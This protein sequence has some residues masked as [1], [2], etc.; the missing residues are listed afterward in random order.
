MMTARNQSATIAS[1]TLNM[2]L[3]RDSQDADTWFKVGWI[4]KDKNGL[5]GEIYILN[6][7][8]RRT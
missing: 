4:V 8:T 3:A 2:E 7:F 6:S 1:V 5:T